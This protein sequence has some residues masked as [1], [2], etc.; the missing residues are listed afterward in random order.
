VQRTKINGVGQPGSDVVAS[1]LEVGA[2]SVL[3][4][5]TLVDAAVDIGLTRNT[6]DLRFI[7]SFPI[8][9]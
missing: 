9:F 1:F 3:S 6:P 8:H 2:S 7:L 4:A 5:S